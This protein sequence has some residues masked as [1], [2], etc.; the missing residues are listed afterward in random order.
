M[1][2]CFL[3]Y[4]IVEWLSE[5]PCL[6][7]FT[8]STQLLCKEWYETQARPYSI[9]GFPAYI[10][11]CNWKKTFI[12]KSHKLWFARNPQG[13]L[14][15]S[16]YSWNRSKICRDKNLCLVLLCD[17]N[18]FGRS[19][20]VLVWPN[21]FGLDHN[22]L[23]STKMKWS[24]PKWIGQVQIVIFYQ[25]ESHLDLTNSCWSW[26]FHFGCDQIIMVKSKSIWSDQ[27]HFGPT[28][29]VLVT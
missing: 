27:N 4:S 1:K 3:F 24:R 22:D 7:L 26:P 5:F 2:E 29:T 11:V 13:I 28:K 23:V 17:Q 21:W 9:V 14:N 20:M 18:S 15:N 8:Y 25:N 10:L 6:V 12:N 16:K 19:K